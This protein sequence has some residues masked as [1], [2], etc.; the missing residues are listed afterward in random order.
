MAKVPYS[1]ETLPKIS[2]VWVGRTNVT[3]RRQ[4][5]DRQT[6][7]RRQT[8]GRRHIA[9]MNLSSRS[10]KTPSKWHTITTPAI[11]Y[12]KW[13]RLWVTVIRHYGKRGKKTKKI[14]QWK[15]NTWKSACRCVR[16]RWR[17]LGAVRC[18]RCGRGSLSCSCVVSCRSS[19]YYSTS[20]SSQRRAVCSHSRNRWPTPCGLLAPTPP[21][22]LH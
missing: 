21:R 6:S 5:D 19:F 16:C 9:N 8:D 17:R 4:T 11:Q 10:L 12:T 13:K 1:V 20:L 7:D 14:L 15:G 3:D 2:I 22:R 18:G